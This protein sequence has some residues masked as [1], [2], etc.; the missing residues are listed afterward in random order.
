MKINYFLSLFKVVLLT[1]SA[2]A[3]ESMEELNYIESTPSFI[4]SLDSNNLLTRES[5]HHWLKKEPWLDTH[6]NLSIETVEFSKEEAAFTDQLFAIENDLGDR[7][8]LKTFR[9]PE[10]IVKLNNVKKLNKEFANNS[11]LP[12]LALDRWSGA[13]KDTLGKNHYISILE[14]AQ[15]D[16][17]SKI[18]D[19]VCCKNIRESEFMEISSRIATVMGQMHFQT[20]TNL[21]TEDNGLM[22]RAKGVHGDLHSSNF[23]VDRSTSP[24]TVTLIDLDT[25]GESVDNPKLLTEDW[26]MLLTNG[27]SMSH[28]MLLND[29]PGIN[30]ELLTSNFIQTYSSQFGPRKEKVKTALYKYLVS[31]LLTT[32]HNQASE[33]SEG[34]LIFTSQE[35][36]IAS[37]QSIANQLDIKI[38]G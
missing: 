24:L 1:F 34:K 18:F 15:G 36:L 38:E 5:L 19:Q 28:I 13:Y 2:H 9:N 7:V 31:F 32:Y 30:C 33:V 25:L 14:Y 27:S 17:F 3:S 6:G 11:N 8:I 21:D 35:N 16:I 23:F 10:S 4:A 20:C 22:L 37:L 26:L 29:R 12:L